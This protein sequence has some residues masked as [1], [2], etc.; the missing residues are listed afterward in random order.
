VRAAQL[1][2][3]QVASV[4]IF[5]AAFF[6]PGEWGPSDIVLDS[7]LLANRACTDIAFADF[8]VARMAAR[9][10]KVIERLRFMVQ[11]FVPD[12]I[13]VEQP[14]P[15]LVLR[16]AL[17]S[18]HNIRIIY[19]SQNIEWKARL[20]LFQLGM[21]T[22]ASDEMLT[23]TR[24]LEKE[25]ARSADLVL[26]ISDMEGEEIKRS[27]GTT[28]IHVPAMS[29]L[30]SSDQ[31]S[32]RSR[33]VVDGRSVGCRYAALMGSAYWPNV[34]GFFSIFPDG[35]GFLAQGE[36]IWVGGTLGK[37]IQGD[38][39]FQTFMSLN[40]TRYRNV[41]FVEE[42]E[43]EAF[44][45][46]ADCVIVPVTFGAGAKQKTADAI[47]SGRPV[48]ATQHAID[49]YGPIVVPAIDKGVYIGNEPHTFRSLVREALRVGLPGCAPEVRARVSLDEVSRLWSHHATQLLA[50]SALR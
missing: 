11:Q 8:H 39:R 12:V 29:E 24:L 10:S 41:G 34:E 7:P 17:P 16:K 22:A 42:H 44:F 1:A 48:I 18:C 5:P 19:S 3:W 6:S 9:D 4:G 46:T 2:G 43:K 50:R 21:K 27:T 31:I 35:L 25:C 13:Q 26:T 47:A 14:W 30:A 37:A 28:A 15:W 38:D 33:L 20:P 49:G 32:V 23:A 36:Q 45:A 40:E